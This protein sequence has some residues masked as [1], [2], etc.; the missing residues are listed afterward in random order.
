MPANRPANPALEAIAE[1]DIRAGAD[2]DDL[3]G[4]G[5]SGRAN[6]VRSNLLGR[7]TLGRFGWKAGQVTIAAPLAAT[8]S[9]IN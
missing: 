6:H 9:S 5:I 2:P 4:D 3:D 1:G 8:E 7:T